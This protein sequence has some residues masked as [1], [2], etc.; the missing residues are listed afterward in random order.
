[1]KEAIICHVFSLEKTET[2]NN[3][4]NNCTANYLSSK[5][6]QIRLRSLISLFV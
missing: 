6:I 2:E 1:M 5:Y 4:Y 3:W